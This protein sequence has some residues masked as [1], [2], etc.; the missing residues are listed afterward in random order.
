MDFDYEHA[1][2]CGLPEAYERL[3]LDAMK[4][5]PL[6]FMR[7]EEVDAQWEFITPI[8]EAWQKLP[9]PKFPNYEAGTW[10][11]TEANRLVEDVQGDWRE[12]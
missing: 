11:P 12:P 1:F 6:L 4:G 8:L 7:S 3:L 2:H 5:I 10:G 9:P